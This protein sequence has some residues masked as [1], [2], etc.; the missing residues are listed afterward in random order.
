MNLFLEMKIIKLKLQF[1]VR[2]FSENYYIKILIINKFKLILITFI[3]LIIQEKHF[4]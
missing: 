3:R 1:K 2:R 4:K